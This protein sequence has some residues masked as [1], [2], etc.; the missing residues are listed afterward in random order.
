MDM[1]IINNNIND[2]IKATAQQPARRLIMRSKRTLAFALMLIMTSVLFQS[3]LITNAHAASDAPLDRIAAVVNS[4][5][6]MLSEV[7]ALANRLKKANPE[8]DDRTLIK[9]ALD[10]LVMTRL[11]VQKAKESGIKIDDNLVNEAVES[12]ARQNKLN[13]EQ[14][15]IA[16]A[17]E[18]FDYKTF[19]Q[20][21]REKLLLEALR[22]R[23]QGRRSVITEQ[24]VDD[25]I[26]SES[27]QLNKDVQYH[28]QDI[29]LPA[30]NG[31]SVA[32]FNAAYKKAGRLRQQ[33][34]GKQQFLES[35]ALKKY[36]ASGKD[37]GWQGVNN[38]KPAFVRALSLMQVGEISPLIRDPQGLH[39]LKL[40]DK[41]GGQKKITQQAHV[42]HILIPDS[43][44]NARIKLLQLRQKIL[45]GADFASLAKQFSSDKGSAAKGGDLG[46]VNPDVFVP[47]FAHAVKTLPI[48]TLSQP[49]KTRFGWHLVQVLE[50]TTSD[51]TRDALKAQAQ[52]LISAKKQSDQYKLWL[53]GLRDN[54]YIDVR[55]SI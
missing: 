22:K 11:Q 17:K 4:D 15:R 9:E 55:L 35:K 48:N 34:L 6:I 27:Y 30:P 24:E 51:Q 5:V 8:V 54:A 42:R 21:I 52:N 53:Q 47:P 25:L 29:L 28:L 39:I 40:V 36:R 41:K 23:Q 3:L 20:T 31:L 46:T 33:L 7:R 13:L 1:M 19:R 18:G 16:L 38:L 49:I 44:P 2:A 45:A 26:K 43:E 14:F 12:I 50:R 10:K 37:L 32:Q